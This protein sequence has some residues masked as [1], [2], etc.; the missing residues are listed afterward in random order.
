[1]TASVNHRELMADLRDRNVTTV[2]EEQIPEGA[3]P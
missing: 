3:N 2:N 1:M